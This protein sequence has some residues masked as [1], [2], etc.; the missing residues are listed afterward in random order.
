MRRDRGQC[1][2]TLDGRRGLLLSKKEQTTAS[3]TATTNAGVLRFAQDDNLLW[4]VCWLGLCCV[5]TNNSKCNGNCND[6]IQRS[7]A[8]L[9][10]TTL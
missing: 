9:R 4:M 10:M 3:A 7:F 8:A 5:G 2:S 1:R 6:E